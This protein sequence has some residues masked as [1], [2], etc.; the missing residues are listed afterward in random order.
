MARIPWYINSRPYTFDGGG[1]MNNNNGEANPLPPPP[2][3]LF[4]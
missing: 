3:P 4:R 1:E 2:F